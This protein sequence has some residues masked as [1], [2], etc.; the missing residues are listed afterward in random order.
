[1]HS[2]NVRTGSSRQY[3]TQ[4]EQYWVIFGFDDKKLIE[5]NN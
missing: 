5:E 2:L 3:D 4:N 1:M